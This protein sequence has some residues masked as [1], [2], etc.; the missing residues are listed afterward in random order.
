MVCL[1]MLFGNDWGK[2]LIFL[3]VVTHQ[4]MLSLK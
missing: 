4:K 3:L 1:K 2:Y